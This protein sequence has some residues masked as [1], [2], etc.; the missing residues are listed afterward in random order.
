[1]SPNL[2]FAPDPLSDAQVRRGVQLYAMHRNGLHLLTT[3]E[4]TRQ[5]LQFQESA[6]I[7]AKIDPSLIYKIS[8]DLT[9]TPF[10]LPTV[11]DFGCEPDLN[12]VFA[13]TRFTQMNQ[14]C[15]FSQD[16]SDNCLFGSLLILDAWG[17]PFVPFTL[18]PLW[19][20]A[21][22]HKIRFRPVDVTARRVCSSG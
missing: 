5:L 3:A 19:V 22:N 18:V 2:E 11:S 17:N 13:Q 20:K 6:D 4:L 9:N 21:Q 8:G 10:R 7:L 15:T 12:K 14:P 16:P 1:M